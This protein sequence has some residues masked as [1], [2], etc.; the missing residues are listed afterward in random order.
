MNHEDDLTNWVLKT[1]IDSIVHR[2][3]IEVKCCHSLK[4]FIFIKNIL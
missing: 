3:I 2:T 1:M 4:T